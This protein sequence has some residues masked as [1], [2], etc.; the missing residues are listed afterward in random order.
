MGA[1]GHLIY[2]G[3][4]TPRA[5]P[6]LEAVI[7]LCSGGSELTVAVTPTPAGRSGYIAAAPS[8]H[9]TSPTAERTPPRHHEGTDRLLL[10]PRH[11]WPRS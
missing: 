4:P 8:W 6:W 5:L 1:L 7:P 11:P 9:G 10:G 2:D 3:E